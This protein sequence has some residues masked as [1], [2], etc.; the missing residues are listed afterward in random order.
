MILSATATKALEAY[1][2]PG[3]WRSARRVRSTVSAKGLAFVLKGRPFFDHA[4]IESTVASPW[5]RLTPVGRDRSVSGVLDGND[6]RLEDAG[7]HVLSERKQARAAF[8][9]FS[10]FFRWDDLDMSYFANYAFWNYLTLPA[11]L[12]REDISWRE[13]APGILD[14]DFPKSFPTHCRSQRFVF[15]RDTGL[16]HQHLYTPDIIGRFA[17]A[18]NVVVAHDRNQGIAYPS[19]RVV[20]PRTPTGKPL[21][22][23]VLIDIQVHR[24]SVAS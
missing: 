5:C 24:Y 17:R 23:P 9:S 11:L 12:L 16:L 8:S 22:F 14:A 18:A 20:T 4:E 3:L 7:G 1:G 13:T 6:V 21:G 19:R 10:K 15:D 2:G